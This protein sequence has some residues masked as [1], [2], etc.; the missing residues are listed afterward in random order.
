MVQNNSGILCIIPPKVIGW[1][2]LPSAGDEVLEVESEHRATEIMHWRSDMA[3]KEKEKEELI[4]IQEKLNEHLK[5]YRAQLEERRRL[6]I[7]YS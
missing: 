4:A 5:V 7:R 2:D 3:V 6:G 1:R